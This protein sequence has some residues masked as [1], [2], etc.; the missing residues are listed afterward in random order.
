MDL[1]NDGQLWEYPPPRQINIPIDG[2]NIFGKF[3][4][5]RVQYWVV[6]KKFEYPGQY[7]GCV[8][9]CDTVLTYY[10]IRILSTCV[11]YF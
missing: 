3:D 2:I 5:E 9:T 7:S 8:I 6:C 1:K 10:N 4:K 11:K